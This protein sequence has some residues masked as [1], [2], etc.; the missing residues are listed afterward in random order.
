MKKENNLG[1]GYV[2]AP[3][4]IVNV[5]TFINGEAVWY[6]NRWKNLGLKIRRLFIK[7]EYLKHVHPKTIKY[8]IKTIDP[9]NYGQIKINGKL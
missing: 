8:K 6:K 9:K 1:P 5:A 7:P 4:V 2:Y 3:Y